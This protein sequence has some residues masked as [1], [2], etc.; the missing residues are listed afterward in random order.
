MAYDW[1]QIGVKEITNL[2]LYGTIDTPADLISDD[3]IRPDG[4]GAKIEVNMASFMESGPG[5][6]ALGSQ[7]ALVEAF[8]SFSDDSWVEAGKE[9]TKNEMFQAL[10]SR[11][12]PVDGN[13]GIDIKQSLLNDS[14]GGYWERSYIWNS[15]SFK[16]SDS[17]RF[18][19]D[20]DG[21][22]HI[23]N[24]AIVPRPDVQENFDFTG[25]GLLAGIVNPELK[26]RIDP[27]GI[28]RTVNIDFIDN[29][30]QFRDY[31]YND[32]QSDSLAHAGHLTAGVASA[33][34]TGTVGLAAIESQ[35]WN[36]GVTK[37]LYQGKA[38]IYGTNGDD[39]LSV[40]LLNEL[41]LISSLKTA[42]Q[43]NGVALIAAAGNDVLAGGSLPDYLQGG[44]GND[45]LDGRDNAGGDFL[46]GG[47]GFDTYY[48]DEGDTIRDSDGRGAVH[49]NGKKL[50]LATR[51]K[52]ET[53]YRDDAGN[54]YIKDG[55]RL[56]VGDPLIIENFA[57]GDLG[58]E[59]EEEQDDDG[60]LKDAFNKAERTVSPLI[61]DLDSNGI[62]TRGIGQ[63]A[64]F[65]HDGNG[66][67]ERTGWV[68]PGDG[69]LVRDLNGDGKITSGAELFGDHTIL[70]NGQRAADGFAALAALDDNADGK[71]DAQDTAWAE[72]QVWR[73]ADSDGR[74][75][76]G[77]LASLLD[78]GVTSLATAHSA[79]SG[80]DNHGNQ[81]LLQGSFT[82]ADGSIGQMEDIWFRINLSSTRQENP[83]DVSA[84]IRK[85][86]NLDGMGN[87]ASL[88]QVMAAQEV[89][90]NHRLKDLVEQFAN[91]SD[92]IARQALITQIIYVWTGVEDKDPASR[93]GYVDAR[94]VF[95]LEALLGESYGQK[96]GANAG[97]HNPGPNAAQVLMAG[98]MEHVF[99]RVYAELM[100][101]THLQE[102]YY[103]IR[104]I[105]DEA[106]QSLKGDLSEVLARFDEEFDLDK[107]E[108]KRGLA[109]FITN[110]THTHDLDLFDT[111]AFQ[112]RLAEYGDDVVSTASLAWRGI[113]ATQGND[114]LIGDNSGE[115]IAGWD[116][117]DI[118]YGRGG[119]DVIQGETGDDLLFG[120]MGDDILNGGAGNDHLDGGKGD[121]KYLFGRG[122]GHDTIWSQDETAGKRDVLKLGEGIV[123]DD[124]TLTRN[125]DDLILAVRNSN[126][127]VTVAGYFANDGRGPTSLEAIEFADGSSWDFE[128]I[129]AMLPSIG[130]EGDDRIRG[131]NTAE[132]ID[133]LN[134]NDVIEGMGGNDVIEGGIGN[135]AIYGGDGDDTL[136]GGRGNDT[137]SGDTGNDIYLFDLGDGQDTI[138]SYDSNQAK[139]DVVLFKEG[140]SPESI[141]VR[142]QSNHLIL[143]IDGTQ[144]QLTIQNYFYNEGGFN[145]YGVEAIRFADGTSWDFATV[146]TKSL[147]AT[148]NS[149]YLVGTPGNDVIEALG[150]NDT[151]DGR[152]GNDTLD[153]GTGNDTLDGGSG[154]DTYLFGIGD[155]QDTIS[156]YD[157]NQA[158]QDVVLFKE[159]ISPESISVRRQ[160]N[161]LIL[162]IDG[163]QDQLTI[164][165]YFYNEGGFNPYGVE[166]IRFADGT[167][168]DFAT[169][170]TK[171]LAATEN[172]DYLVGTPGNDVIEAL[173][174][175]DTLDGR[176]GND[177]LDG[178][179]GNDTLDGGSGDD[180]YLFGIGDG[181]D[182]I[183]SYDSNQA[184]QDVV[185]LK[186]GI[187]PESISVWRQS[188]HLILKIDGTQDQ[189]TIQN[190]FYNEGGF[191]PYGVE[192]I[193]F[194]DG[195][196][197]DF[198]TVKTKSLAATENSDYLVGTPGNDV[199]EALGGNDTLDGR[200]GN[201]TLDGGTGNDTLYG[202]AGDDVLDGGAGNDTLNGG[203]GND[204]YLFDVGDGQDMISSHDSNQAKQDVV[205]FKEGVS[206][207]NIS[208][209]RQSN[210]L[211]LKIDGTQD[212]LTIQ[213]YFYNEGGFN[214]YGVEAIRFADGTSWNFAAVK[215]KSLAGTEGNDYLVGTAGGDTIEGL[216]GDD[217][218]YGRGGNDTLDGG[219]GNDTL[220]GEG[221]DDMLDGGTGNDTLYGEAGDDTLNGGVGNDR[222]NGGSGN[223]TYLFGIGDGQDTLWSHDPDQAKQDVVL[224]KEGVLPE[225]VSVRRQS[226]SLV[227]R[228]NG[229]QDQLTI[230]NYFSNEGGFN[231]YGVEAIRF[232]DGT[233]WNF[234][235]VK[236]KS[237]EAT[238]SDD[239]LYGGSGDDTL[240]GLGGNDQLY[241]QGGNDALDGG[242]GN[243]RLDGGSGNDTYLFGIGDGQDTI[244]SNDLNQAKQDAVLFKEGISSESISVRR[245]SNHLILKVN[246][247][248]D[249]LKIENYFSNEGSFNPYGVE[250]IQFA[251]GTSWNFA[252]VKTKS[253]AATENDDD[254]AG[255]AGDD[256]IE[257][258]GGNDTLHGRE[259]NDTLSGGAG[260]DTLDG[261]PGNDTYLFGIGDGQDTISSHDPN[262]VKQDV[263]LFK[264]G[265]S[266]EDVSVRRQ[267]DSL[268]LR[269][270]G[271]QDQLTIQ[272]YFSNEG[273]FNPYGVEVIR[274]ADGTSWD[275]LAVKAKSI[276]ATE[277][278]D[279]L[280][281]GNGD[282]VLTGLGGND[283]I[284]G[285]ERNDTLDGGPGNDTL[286][287]G[288]GNDTYLFG[289]GDGQD[290]ISSYDSN[291]TK[292]DIVLFKEGVSPENVTI[293]RQTNDLV[294][295]IDGTQDQLTIRY[296][297]SNEGSFNPYG[298]EVIRFADGTS[299]DFAAVQAKSIEVTE[300]DDTLYGGS[301]DDILTGLGGNDQLH[302][303]G[304]NDTLIGGT[305]NDTLDGG[306]GNDTY[307][308]GIGDGQDT[309][310]S[311]DSNQTKQD[312]VLFKEGVSPENVTIRRQTND[313]VLK[314]DGTQDQLTIRYYFSNEGSFNPYGVEVIRFA[315]GTSWDFAA[316]QA[317]SIEATEGDDTLYG[318]N[319]DD[320]LTG[321]GGN[322]QLYGQG[323]NDTLDGG[324][325]NDSLYG[326]DGDD[327]LDGG[328]GNDSLYGGIGDDTLDG[329][330]GNDWL[331]GGSGNDTYLFGIGDGQDMISSYDSNQT[332]QDIVLFK[333]GVSPENVTI[334]RQ[335]G[336]LILKINGTQDQLTV[337]N[338]FSNEGG[339]NPYGVEVIR[340]ADGTSWD[341][342]AVQ[343]KSIEATEGDD[344]LYGGNGD[345]VLTGLGGN[346]QLYGQ[347]GNDTLDGG[348]G[349][350][351]LYGADGDDTLDGGAGNDS[352]YGEIG[353]DTLD[354]GTGNDWLNGGSGNDTYLFGA[355]DG[356]DTISSYDSNQAKQDA[357]LFKEGISP[358]DIIVRRQSNDLILK[359]DGA[360]DQLKIESYFSNEGDFN[361][362]G[363]EAI[364]F[365]DGTS[366]DFATIKA[367]SI[368]GTGSNDA[369][370][371]GN[372]DDVLAGLGGNDQLYGREGNDTLDGGAGN[373]TLDGGTGD[374]TY[375]F[376]L[377]DGQDVISDH[378][379]GTAD[380]DTLQ[381]K[382]GVSQDDVSVIRSGTSL[383]LKLSETGDQVTILRYFTEDGS[384]NPDGVTRI[385]FDDGSTLSYETIQAKSRLGSD[386]NDII[387]GYKVGEVLN[388]G[389]GSDVIFG[390]G[391][392]DTIFGGAG[393]DTYLTGGDG[394]D[395]LYGEAGNDC[396][397]GDAGDDLLDGG[398]GNDDLHGDGGNNTL[399]GGLGNDRL[400]GGDEADVLDGGSGDDWLWGNGGDDALHGGAGNDYLWADAGDDLLDGG[401]GDDN[402]Y[403]G[404][405]ND[406][407]YGGAGNDYLWGDAGDNLLDGGEGD[408][409]ISSGEGGNTLLFG[410][411]DGNDTAYGS[412][413]VQFKPGIS[414]DDVTLKW[415]D[416]V[417]YVSIGQDGIA[418]Y[419]YLSGEIA[420]DEELF[421]FD[422]GTHWDY[423]EVKARILIGSATDSDDLILGYDSND[424]IIG[425]EGNDTLV[426]YG[427]DDTL[428]G[429][430]GD[431]T[432]VGGDGNDTLDGGGGGD[433]LF[434]DGG[435][436]TLAGGDGDDTL[437]G[438]DGNDTLAGG[439]GND[440]LVGDGGD[441]TLDGGAGSDL[442]YFRRGHGHDTI[443]ETVAGDDVN[444]VR[445][446]FGERT[447]DDPA[448]L[449]RFER[450]GD[451]LVMTVDGWEGDSLT[452]ANWF[453]A[454]APARI[455]EIAIET[456]ND[457]TGYDTVVLDTAAIQALIEDDGTPTVTVQD[458]TL[459]LGTAVAAAN[460]IQAT[461]NVQHYQFWDDV[462]GG[463]RFVLDGIDQPA[464]ANISVAADQLADLRYVAGNATATERLWARVSDGTT[465]SDWMPWQMTSAPHL[466]NEAPVVMA[467]DGATGLGTTVAAATLF[468]VS[469]ADGDVP[470]R[471][472]FWDDGQGGGRFVLNGVDQVA[473]T[474]IAVDAGQ[475]ASLHYVGADAMS[476]ERIWARA[477][478][479]QTW[480]EWK[481]WNMLSGDHATNAAPVAQTADVTLLLGESAAAADLFTATDPDGD[482]IAKY[483]F[484]DDTDG[485]GRFVLDGIG[486]AAGAAITIAADDLADLTY[487]AG[488]E[489]GSERVWV[490]AS[491]GVDWG[492]WTPWNI[493]SAAHLT[494]AAPTVSA[495]AG[496]VG[497]GQAVAAATLFTVEDA[498]GDAPTKYEFWDDVDGGGY[499]AKNGVAQ[500][501]GTNIAV[502]AAELAGLAYVG[503]DAASTEQVWVRTSDGLAWSAWTAWNMTSVTGMQRGGPGDDSLIADGGVL[504]GNGGDDALSGPSGNNLLFGGTGEDTLSGGTGDG[505]L[506]GGTGNDTL[507]T[508]TG[509]DVIAFNAGDGNDTVYLNGGADTISLGRGIRY[510]DLALRQEGDDLVLDTGNGESLTFKDWYTD[511]SRQSALNLQLIAETLADFDADGDDP[512]RDDKVEG[513][514]FRLLVDRFDQARA[515]N[516]AI[517]QWHLMSDLLDAHLLGA[518][519]AA[520]GGDLAYQYGRYG[521][522]ANV[523]LTGAQNVLNGSQ[524]AVGPQTFQSLQGLQE[525]VARLG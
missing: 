502:S 478:D 285:R 70:K 14:S 484:W 429:D 42:G 31:S 515:A 155:G 329:G 331:N 509:D 92:S 375:L 330:A 350:D 164:Q 188:N 231:P 185:L 1:T 183:S 326:A 324:T 110:L 255:T 338:Y 421:R 230:Q 179:T 46:D 11:G 45:T 360:Q 446:S 109:V 359:I 336:S 232:A 337:E 447:I 261:G 480:S 111:Q 511:V 418:L 67:A 277:S 36:G 190:Y 404:S 286:D 452:I 474:T 90:S 239:V 333:E 55:S 275:F 139:Q 297:F 123:Q 347:G 240:M 257:G 259:G 372:E 107:D 475:L 284:Y 209:R 298:V 343:A 376:G 287:G 136:S 381:F 51:K 512:L 72:L 191:N 62:S 87:V 68:T 439:G 137:L 420:D 300:G 508:G 520:I 302:G 431:D 227:L 388:G 391:G 86:P 271:T 30:S 323:G 317:K 147:A 19:V 379:A 116:G 443:A 414:P 82:K 143:K 224:F 468:S 199:I 368:E 498:D 129:R 182:T 176:E 517:T 519:D 332:K 194:A 54:I 252:T 148:E 467:N 303:Q 288:P 282:D 215:A 16:L 436:D 269:I 93:G 223:D 172:S 344:T 78:V 159:G 118:I 444:T 254:L 262:Q 113:V 477:W 495:T 501:A 353:D 219:D 32:Y 43:V 342:A 311:Y 490:R 363:V 21:K 272:Y 470:T 47:D 101:Q 281:G 352:L 222:L 522:F 493:T 334:R 244:S 44:A 184:K 89:V 213:N 61:L 406:A 309:I 265:V 494:N 125:V 250:V 387:Y 325:G 479:G 153:G 15:G 84:A 401:E 5:R 293:R 98:Y 505:F 308:F 513:F 23:K 322:D 251:D 152:E 371:G 202:S 20:A 207:E 367:K 203:A 500:A 134:G 430:D 523:G 187:S 328:A 394:N 327:T 274:F 130:T 238:E 237:I 310:S 279:V 355:G 432:L 49:L 415:K 88:W 273:G 248:Q 217:T 503:G 35:L 270:N 392:D 419:G 94:V 396:L 180:T 428:A 380:Q 409:V 52:G 158:K 206:P 383:I 74:V 525:G 315:D 516:A 312:I 345:D 340:F 247:T 373:D 246:G 214:P 39:S 174:G 27:W 144:D 296:Y 399:I 487:A 4:D 208:L 385:R 506:A 510:A 76:V 397:W 398:E 321:L 507:S 486:Q 106:N 456:W 40:S 258:L 458:R 410:A 95:A 472:E 354:G 80:T 267:S 453:S 423:A 294:L 395:T 12:V 24:Y 433:T 365:A 412:F 228:I 386:G 112:E 105:W 114:R 99:L 499:F 427:G 210:H 97:T 57:D 416:G 108:A 201:D 454:T 165:N 48:A 13:Y 58:I 200:E 151:L 38:I 346:D 117:D 225:D 362:Y 445:M 100:R 457:A 124:L 291:Q 149:D 280:Y 218:L 417:H 407:L 66:F 96:E 168:W 193:R 455:Q 162:K 316:V 63:G 233:S 496:V 236:A 462:D 181:Q 122:D 518:D 403:G 249:Q 196:S 264:E 212:Q 435:D 50:S 189:L 349:N 369:L 41:P 37:A 524:F 204:T 377:G 242:A 370:Y 234:A 471:Y 81:H 34:L 132:V 425:K 161:H 521:N 440:T 26:A 102:D 186:E 356:Q 393:D 473:G 389:N 211:I 3:R 306:S 335:W 283:W 241:G 156:S 351:S 374:D 405:G 29:I 235:A 79:G 256:V 197:W 170:K 10:T 476:R 243:D 73:D 463:G 2:Y 195:T 466:T 56:L 83:L 460:L 319:G 492:E 266:P 160:S 17:A 65:D 22:R 305:G 424:L 154:D 59:L 226:D 482:P 459:L 167:S 464:G 290:T 131:Y 220:Y 441:D 263:V 451:D 103:A 341:F 299:W 489:T 120:E 314:I 104:Y 483:E 411:G 221:S 142:R 465:W 192:A 320:V 119:N 260:N 69:L 364:R 449:L 278:D 9:Y 448:A 25:D 135:D 408:D 85:M 6:F 33:L 442:Y 304:G 434:G 514:D 140:I 115:I 292:Q 378:T 150:G 175:N 313:L 198:A 127:R 253:L 488:N 450:T 438:G 361:P 497:S 60:P 177:T 145:P 8:F 400:W 146:K 128:A 53:A 28:G 64:F 133:G 141:S 18:V 422:D 75:D 157:S 402:L 229:T 491:D 382:S 437:V 173:G 163:T 205:L 268:V 348:T 504:L 461:G 169:V 216:G 485:G 426:G 171:S 121:D 295:K 245:Q 7:S 366:W 91:E 307:L 469:D 318:G 481:S 339:F 384:L 126:D 413:F 77:E 289:I 178:G 71:V 390:Y 358:K 357:V 276:E 301:G 166:A 138:S